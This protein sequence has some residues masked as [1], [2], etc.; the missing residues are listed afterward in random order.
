MTANKQREAC[1]PGSN[2]CQDCERQMP[3][4]HCEGQQ[5]HRKQ[6]S[7]NV[8]C[9]AVSAANQSGSDYKCITY[10]HILNNE[11]LSQMHTGL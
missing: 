3:A 2:Q 9:L 5:C 10:V 4:E 6:S 11:L 8:D 7:H 1:L